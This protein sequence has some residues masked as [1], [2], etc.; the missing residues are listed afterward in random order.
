MHKPHAAMIAA[1]AIGAAAPSTAMAE[2]RGPG[3]VPAWAY[4]QRPWQGWD[5][6]TP[7]VAGLAFAPLPGHRCATV[8]RPRYDFDGNVVGRRL[9]HACG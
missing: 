9:G 8:E 4:V 5:R 7:A 2:V 6:V 1:L 3:W